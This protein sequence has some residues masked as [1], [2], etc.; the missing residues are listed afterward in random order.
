M[1]FFTKQSSKDFLFKK[2]SELRS[3]LTEGSSRLLGSVIDTKASLV[4]GISSKFDKV[5]KLTS[6][7]EPAEAS[8][9]GEGAARTPEPGSTTAALAVSS[10]TAGHQNGAAAT[11]TGSVSH[12]TAAADCIVDAYV[13]DSYKDSGRRR[14]NPFLNE[15][16]ADVN[17]FAEDVT[18][19]TGETE[20]SNST[21]SSYYNPFRSADNSAHTTMSYYGAGAG[22]GDGSRLTAARP[23]DPFAITPT[24]EQALPKPALEPKRVQRASTGGDESDGDSESTEGCDENPE[25]PGD[26]DFDGGS[27]DVGGRM[28]D[29][30]LAEARRLDDGKSGLASSGSRFSD[31]SWS[32]SINEDAPMDDLSRQSMEFMRGF[33][34][35]VFDN[36]Y[37]GKHNP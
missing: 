12:S 10:P 19:A 24:S 17:P 34:A 33:V 26:D 20:N 3:S 15:D 27:Q 18:V 6:G 2:S 1:S 31:L 29:L 37:M 9:T 16:L 32:S 13:R 5:V 23:V 36:R 25:D 14:T 30:G 11:V 7:S 21:N 22:T 28:A 35:K 8:E 4:D